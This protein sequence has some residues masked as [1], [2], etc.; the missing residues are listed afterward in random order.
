MYENG[1]GIKQDFKEAAKW[2]RQAADQGDSWAQYNLGV[3]YLHGQGVKQDPEESIKLFRKAAEQGH[4]NAQHNLNAL[5]G[6]GNEASTDTGHGG[7][8]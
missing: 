5:T 4:A 7:S 2:F 8:K 1:Q 6:M 3:M